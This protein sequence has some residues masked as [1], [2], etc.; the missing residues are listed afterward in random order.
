MIAAVVLAAGEGRRMGRPKALM[1]FEGESLLRRSVK[2][3]LASGCSPVMAVVGPW[4][5]DLGD[6]DVQVI[7]NPMAKEG[8][9]SSI[10]LGVAALGADVDAVLLLTVDQ[11]MVDA[12]LLDDLGELFMQDPSRPAACGY[13][14]TVGVP[15]LFPRHLFPDLMALSGDRGAK[16]ILLRNEC[17]RLP[18]PAGERDLDRPSDLV[19]FRR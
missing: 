2:V 12:D 7:P 18:F 1:D 10:R 9:A 5:P 14:G 19:R 6:L 13:A 3:A 16:A 17:A 11:P 15:A 4:E 8:M